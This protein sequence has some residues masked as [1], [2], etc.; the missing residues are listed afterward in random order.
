MDYGRREPISV[1]R[2]PGDEA[3]DGFRGF[4][5]LLDVIGD[6]LTKWSCFE[7][8]GFP[9]AGNEFHPERAP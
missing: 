8:G 2:A 9:A 6:K 4:S 7:R 3:Q 5:D 1:C